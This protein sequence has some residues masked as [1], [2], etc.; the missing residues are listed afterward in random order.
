MDKFPCIN[1]MFFFILLV[2]S[3]TFSTCLRFLVKAVELANTLRARM[4]TDA[5]ASVRSRFGGLLTLLDRHPTCF[6]VQ[7]IP[8]ADS[9]ALC[10]AYTQAPS[11]APHLQPQ[12]QPQELNQ[13]FHHPA[14]PQVQPP[15]FQ[16]QLHQLN[17]RQQQQQQSPYQQQQAQQPFYPQ[18]PS[19]PPS[20]NQP[21]QGEQLPQHAPFFTNHVT[22]LQQESLAWA[23]PS[24]SMPGEW[25][26]GSEW[27]PLPSGASPS[28]S[29]PMMAAATSSPLPPPPLPSPPSPPPLHA[30]SFRHPLSRSSFDSA[31]SSGSS[32]SGGY[33]SSS[34]SYGSFLGPSWLDANKTRSNSYDSF[35]SS[36]SSQ[37][38]TTD[39]AFGPFVASAGAGGGVSLTSSSIL[40]LNSGAGDQPTVSG[41]STGS[42]SSRRNTASSL[43]EV[44]VL[45]L[46]TTERCVPTQAWPVQANR[47]EPVVRALCQLLMELGGGCTISKL[48][49]VLKLRL[50]ATE[51]VKSV[52]LKVR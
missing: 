18:Q 30:A 29:P 28:V 21:Y 37:Q 42:S 9:V 47:D 44:D 51:S 19:L 39:A 14:P 52:P 50:G 23:P 38:D 40:G 48:R 43:G 6:H 41:S 34:V 1:V 33:N 35:A 16:H 3:F 46:L 26:P 25:K 36:S 15:R 17:Q 20:L 22:G 32:G 31:S 13:Q 5:L 2:S 49:S 27:T 4:G 7:R 10:Y 8:K 24:H 12:S 45:E 11:S